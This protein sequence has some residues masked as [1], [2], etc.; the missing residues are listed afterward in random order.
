MWDL[1]NITND[2]FKV[3]V[4]LAGSL[5]QSAPGSCHHGV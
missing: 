1:K 2:F 5:A 3:V 4:V